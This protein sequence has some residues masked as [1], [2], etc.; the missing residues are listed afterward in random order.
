M[1]PIVGASAGDLAWCRSAARQ[2]LPSSMFFPPE[3]SDS[4]TAT[5]GPSP[6]Q[7]VCA[8]CSVTDQGGAWALARVLEEAD[9]APGARTVEWDAAGRSG[10]HIVRVTVDDDSESQIVTLGGV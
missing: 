4:N 3:C 8:G 9:P 6:A 1:S 5:W 10:S 2:G 7:A